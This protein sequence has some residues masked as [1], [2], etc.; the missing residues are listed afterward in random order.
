MNF[1]LTVTMERIY[2]DW[3]TPHN[4][5][6]ALRVLVIVLCT[7]AACLLATQRGTVYGQTI[8]N[9]RMTMAVSQLQTEG[10]VQTT[11]LSTVERQEQ[12]NSAKIDAMMLTI[13]SLQASQAGTQAV[14]ATA[15]AIIGAL[16]TLGFFQRRRENK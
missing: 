2:V 1:N 8:L 13:A 3:A 16:S 5:L 10:A 14:G 7:I 12:V 11:R 6:S 4:L 15:F 9:E